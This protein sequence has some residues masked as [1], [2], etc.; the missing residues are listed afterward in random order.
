MTVL[1]TRA[2]A[3]GAMVVGP[4][5]GGCGK[6]HKYEIGLSGYPEFTCHEGCEDFARNDPQ[7]ATMPA[8]VPDDYDEKITREDLEQRSNKR[9][10]L[11]MAMAAARAVGM[12]AEADMLALQAGIPLS[13]AYLSCPSGHQ[14]AATMKYCGVCGVP[15]SAEAR[16][17]CPSCSH[18]NVPGQKFCGECAAPMRQATARAALDAPERSAQSSSATF[19]PERPRRL[20]DARLDELQALAR[21]HGVSDSGPRPQL[22][23]RLS[24]AGVTSAALNALA[25]A[26]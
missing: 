20:R 25:T 18:E 11:V 4:G 8:K 7:H 12:N 19:S 17:L 14:N 1:A 21:K 16:V 24:E 2:H 15:I 10:D 3:N 13:T 5:H 22:I 9:Q 23:A 6:T 26:A